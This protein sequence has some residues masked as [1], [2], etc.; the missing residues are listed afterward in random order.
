MPLPFS[1]MPRSLNPAIQKGTCY[2]IFF[3]KDYRTMSTSYSGTFS[4]RIGTSL[5]G[6]TS[7]ADPTDLLIFAC[8]FLSFIYVIYLGAW[9]ETPESRTPLAHRLGYFIL[10]N[11]FGLAPSYV[12]AQ[13]PR[14]T[15]LGLFNMFFSGFLALLFG[16]MSIR[17]PW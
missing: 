17:G 9:N 4:R 3:A 8:Y 11:V 12:F 16:I 1:N 2:Q 13:R 15:N 14:L 5:R 6:L 7:N 10:A